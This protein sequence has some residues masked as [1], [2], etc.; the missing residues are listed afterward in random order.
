MKIANYHIEE[1]IYQGKK[2]SV[3]RAK[4]KE[5]G[6]SYVLKVLEKKTTDY[7]EEIK[8]LKTENRFLALLNSLYVIKQVDWLEDKDYAVLIMEDIRGEAVKPQIPSDGFPIDRFLQLAIQITTGLAHI[9]SRNIIH[10]DINPTNIILNAQTGHLKIIDFNIAS[11][12]DVKLSY[13]GNPDKLRGTL[14]YISPE[15]TG[16]IN[17]K[18]DKRTDLYSLGATF[19]KMLTCQRPFQY[20][21]PMEIVYAHLATPPEP[22][23]LVNSRIPK[24]LS[25]IVLKLMA[26]NPEERYQSAEGLLHDL[27]TCSALN[28]AD[29]ILGEKD[30][31]G[32]LQIPEKLYGRENEIQQL[33]G[34]YRGVRQGEKRMLMVAGYSGTGKTAL[35]NEIHKPITKDRGYFVSGKFD[36]LQ[37]TMPYYAFI[38]ALNQF[39]QLL[40]SEDEEV[41]ANWRERILLAVEN[42]GKVLTDLIPQVESV[43]GKQPDVPDADGEEARRRSNYVFQR[44]IQAVATKEHPLIIFID[45]LQWADLPSLDLLKTLMEKQNN[46]LLFIGAYR[47]NETSPAHPLM[48]TLEDIKEDAGEIPTISIKN[49]SIQHVREL[50]QDTLKKDDSEDIHALADLVYQKTRGN[51]FFT[52]QFLENLYKEDLLHFEPKKSQWTWDI[53]VIKKKDITDNVVDLLVRKLR[54]FP[55]ATQEVLKL[56]ACIG[57]T[58]D[59]DTLAVITP[60][61]KEHHEKNLE[62]ALAQQVIYPKS[63]KTFMFTHDRLHQAAYSLIAEKERKSL[64]LEIGRLLLKN[65]QASHHDGDSHEAAQALFE[66]VNH[67]NTGIDLIDTGAEKMTLGEFNLRACRQ[68]KRSGAYKIGLNYIQNSIKLLP[69]NP[70]KEHYDNALAVF[71][72]AIQVAYLCVNFEEMEVFIEEVMANTPGIVDRIVAYY[73]RMQGYFA[74]HQPKLVFETILDVFKK[75]EIDIPANPGKGQIREAL[76]Q[77]AGLYREKGKEVFQDGPMMD[78]PQMQTAIQLYVMGSIGMLY[79]HSNLFHYTTAKMMELFLEEGLTPEAPFV[80]SLYGII[81]NNAG[82]VAGAYQVGKYSVDLLPKVNLEEITQYKTIYLACAYL[83][84]WKEHFK[85]VAKRLKDNYHNTLNVGEIEYA[86]YS[87]SNYAIY[88][89]RTDTNLSTV[90]DVL[91]MS[92]EASGQLKQPITRIA[93]Q[94]DLASVL[95]LL[96]ETKNPAVMELDVSQFPPNFDEGALGAVFVFFIHIRKAFLAFLFEDYDSIPGYLAQ[97]DS[98]W[99]LMG[100]PLVFFKI[101]YYLIS[102]LSY[103]QLYTRSQSEEEKKKYLRTIRKNLKLMKEWAQLGPANFLHKY[104]LLQ[105]ELYRLTCRTQLAA[106]FYDKAIETAFENEYIN[107]AAIANELAAKFYIQRRKHKLA[108][109]YLTEARSC[110]RKW[111]AKAKVDFLEKNYPKYLGMGAQR[112]VTQTGTVSSS[113]STYNTGD[114]LDVKSILNASHTLSGEVKLKNLLEKLMKILIENAGAQRSLLIEKDG[115]LLLVQAENSTNGIS[116][117]L[118]DIPIEEFDKIPHSIIRYVAHSHH[119]LVFDNLSADP[120]Y[121]A[122]PYVRQTQPKSAVCFPILSKGRLIAVIYLENNLMEGVFTSPR[123]EILNM[124]SSQI[125]ISVENTHLYENLEEKV[126]HRTIELQKAHQELERNHTALE[127]SHRQI[128]DSVYYASRIQNAALPSHEALEAVFPDHFVFYSPHS[129]VSGDF[130]WAK[131]IDNKKVVAAA[132]CTGHGVPGALVSM[133]GMAFLNE[134]VLQLAVQN[135]LTADNV[136]NHLRDKVKTALKQDEQASIHRD[137]MDIALCIIDTGKKQIQY[138]GAYSP[139]YLY[140]G[141]KLIETRA[142]RMPIGIARRERPFTHHDI[143]Y[144]TGDMI[145]LFSDGFVD[146]NTEK[147][148][149]KKYTRKR[150]KTFLHKINQLPASKQRD[151]LITEFEEWKGN[152]AQRDDLLIMGIRL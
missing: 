91:N 108:S 43:I 96:G 25:E 71:N 80:L 27:K 77:T 75:L 129:V 48:T 64:H 109:F 142:D 8:T 78:N 152:L 128:N 104:Y 62:A 44:F 52:I 57:N 114:F 19:Y 81:L 116:G 16:R 100:M 31:S 111:G 105:A 123:L 146:Q 87:V 103:C 11:R 83:L 117:T 112:T 74:R 9:H 49:L 7:F 148:T 13:S 14:P 89:T 38:Q 143:P 107:E 98:S 131:E 84:G 70:W 72:E 121:S 151:K 20:Q 124:L 30:F 144:Q 90:K 106:E 102:T 12:Y 35:V 130:Y 15:Q 1:T 54:S 82:D 141:T 60:Q 97:A 73:I 85:D 42:M 4:G 126:K 41:L 68:A 6:T 22:P 23:H 34:A 24:I 63:G 132:D 136:L 79:V 137:G 140:R 2:T 125:A 69:P 120:Q 50:L 61:D 66:V 94:I 122:D 134:I 101:D 127:T 115:D 65:F 93:P 138:A 135:Q 113:I 29:F 119:Q 139:L 88:L 17:R 10:K 150:F 133:L 86:C 145:Y 33:L 21:D 46:Y 118:Q 18:V 55:A 92:I 56:A 51:A 67:L 95:G 3:Y 76:K 45:D 28:M 32:I 47:D 53:A 147:D 39:C 37:R 5:A 99:A 26:K 110:Y 58:F 59:L 149:E 36:Q 40:L